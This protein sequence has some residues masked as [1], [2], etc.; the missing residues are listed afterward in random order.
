MRRLVLIP[1]CTQ[2][3]RS[4][5]KVSAVY[6]VGEM[7]RHQISFQLH[8]P[9]L[10]HTLQRLTVKP[11]MLSCSMFETIAGVFIEG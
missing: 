2:K 10:L 7:R 11:S 9:D 3:R 5:L 1:R 6:F 4:R 8:D